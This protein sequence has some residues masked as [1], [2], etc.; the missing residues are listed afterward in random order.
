MQRMNQPT[1]DAMQPPTG[2]PPT[3]DRRHGRPGLARK[4]TIAAVALGMALAASACGSSTQTSQSASTN[5]TKSSTAASG[6]NGGKKVK[7]ALILKDISNPYWFSMRK[8]EN[9]KPRNPAS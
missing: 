7:I 2:A 9:K 5:G 1:T 6:N 8:P 3:A 4:G